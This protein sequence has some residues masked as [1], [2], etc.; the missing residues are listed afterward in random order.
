MEKVFEAMTISISVISV[1][2]TFLSYSHISN[3]IEMD[4]K[5]LAL[6]LI[7]NILPVRRRL[8]MLRQ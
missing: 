7:I 3:I 1:R 4:N 8:Q 5:G 2:Y 6:Y